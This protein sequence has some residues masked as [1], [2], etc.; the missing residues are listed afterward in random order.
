MGQHGAA[1]GQNVGILGAKRWDFG[2]RMPTF[3]ISRHKG[4][5][6]GR[7]CQIWDAKWGG[8]VFWSQCFGAE[9]WDFGA[10]G[11]DWGQSCGIWG[12]GGG[13]GGSFGSEKGDLC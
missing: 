3:E 7:N 8:G 1:L 9:G 11:W 12:L 13:E 6:W 5:I 10:G 2:A 4:G